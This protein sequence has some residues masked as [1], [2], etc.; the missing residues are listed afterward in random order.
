MLAGTAVAVGV[1]VM[2][3]VALFDMSAE[4]AVVVGEMVTATA[5]VDLLAS[6]VAAGV[7]VDTDKSVSETPVPVVVASNITPFVLCPPL[8]SSAP[9]LLSSEAPEKLQVTVVEPPVT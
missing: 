5:V 8:N 1:I 9:H 2:D 7:S 4:T 3:A 6:P